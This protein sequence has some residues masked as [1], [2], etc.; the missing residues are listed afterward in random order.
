MNTCPCLVPFRLRIPAEGAL[1]RAVLME[2]IVIGLCNVQRAKS[3]FFVPS[4][5]LYLNQVRRS[6][7]FFPGALFTIIMPMFRGENSRTLVGLVL[8]IVFGGYQLVSSIPASHSAFLYFLLASDEEGKHTHCW[9][10]SNR[11]VPF[12]ADVCCYLGPR[13]LGIPV[14]VG[15]V[16][17]EMWGTYFVRMCLGSHNTTRERESC[18]HRLKKR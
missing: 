4:P 5:L 15:S 6:C 12:C 7:C 9:F 11:C 8:V 16:L 2:S 3:L 18:S 17:R 13:S 1:Q 14:S 10:I